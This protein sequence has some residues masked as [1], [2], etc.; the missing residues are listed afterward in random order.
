ME[1]AANQTKAESAALMK[2]LGLKGTVTIDRG[3]ITV[4]IAKHAR[5]G[6][7]LVAMGSRGLGAMDRFM[8]GSVSN[9]EIHHAPCPVLVV[10]EAPRSV[11]QI[12]LA[13]DGSPDSDKAVRFLLRHLAPQTQGTAKLPVNITVVPAMPGVSY[14]EMREASR[15]IL[16]RVMDKVAKAGFQVHAVLRP[17][18]PA[19]ETLQ[20]AKRTKAAL[21]ITGA[22]GL[23]AIG[24]LV[25][26]SVSTR[27]V[28]HSSCSVLVVR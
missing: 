1:T 10:K 21:I 25:L 17:G 19:E 7:G 18:K 8:L 2:S 12:V 26:G 15:T 4:S 9:Y 22:T 13:I 14:P 20:A 16:Q 27:V 6:I 3:G 23:G 28:Q 5:R 24:R 11:R